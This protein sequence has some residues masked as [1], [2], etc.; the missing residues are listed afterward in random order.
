MAEF[1]RPVIVGAEW[2]GFSN[3]VTARHAGLRPVA[4]VEE[5]TRPRVPG[6][7]GAIARGLFGVRLFTR[8]RLVA[9]IGAHRVE[10]VEVECD[11]HR[12]R[13]ACDGVIFSGEFVPEATLVRAGGL[14]LDPATGGPCIDTAWRCSDPAI[15][16]A[17][18]LLR[19]VE[20][21][22]W[23]SREG[24]LAASAILA[25]LGG[26][27]RDSQ[28]VPV[29]P[30]GVLRYVYP[31]R[32][33]LDGSASARLTLYGRASAPSLGRLRLLADGVEVA[34]RRVSRRVEARLS[35]S[36]PLDRLAGCTDLVATLE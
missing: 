33:L 10:A 22:G 2:V 25:A 32:I 14:A 9:I 18:D 6:P 34:R 35:I 36:L 31:Q 1:A 20:N 5:G 7:A 29:R 30:G 21:A 3:L 12:R 27:A 13:I 16:A 19:P 4:I 28:A 15:F 26:P 11:G 24:R 23:A 17:G 8:T